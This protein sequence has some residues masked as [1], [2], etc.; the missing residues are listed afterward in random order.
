M[1]GS[2]Q[3]ASYE[4]EDGNTNRPGSGSKQ[5]DVSSE[6]KNGKC[7]VGA[8]RPF[9]DS[10]SCGVKKM[11]ISEDFRPTSED[12]IIEGSTKEE[13]DTAADK[14]NGR[15]QYASYESEDGNTNGAGNGSEQHD[16]SSKAKNEICSVGA[17]RPF[18]DSSTCEAKEMVTFDDKFWQE[19][20]ERSEARFGRRY[21]RRIVWKRRKVI[22]WT[23]PSSSE[24]SD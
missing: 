1:N 20:S 23:P 15:E 11:Q 13:T 24:S 18:A 16:I 3:Y 9:P 17:K 22:S 21:K 14:M 5:H 2:D 19:R 10:S 8:K 7:C 12:V 6:V 4:S